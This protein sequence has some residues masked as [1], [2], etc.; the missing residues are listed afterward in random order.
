[1]VQTMLRTPDHSP[2]ASQAADPKPQPVEAE[3]R[4]T[5]EK[6]AEPAGEDYASFMAAAP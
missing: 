2:T 3:Q 4:D 5:E 6:A 1:M